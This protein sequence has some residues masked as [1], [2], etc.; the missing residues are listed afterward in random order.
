[1]GLDPISK[2]TTGNEQRHGHVIAAWKLAQSSPHT[3]RAYNRSMT[4]F[5]SW[6]DDRGMDLL[7]IKR[8]IIDG[9]RHALAS[10]SPATVAA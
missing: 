10:L 9:Y 3:L 2:N 7:T 6:L 5:C 8:P 1:M 4:D